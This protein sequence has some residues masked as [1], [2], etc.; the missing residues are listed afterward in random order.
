VL[1]RPHGAREDRDDAGLVLVL[2]T[3]RALARAGA[4]AGLL[5]RRGRPLTRGCVLPGR[6]HL[7]PWFPST[8]ACCAIH[9]SAV[10]R[11]DPRNA[12][13]NVPRPGLTGGWGAPP[14]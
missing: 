4:L 1:D 10:N 9:L 13:Q 11:S 14:V 7:S 6:A 2:P 8:G 3:T 12:P 5:T